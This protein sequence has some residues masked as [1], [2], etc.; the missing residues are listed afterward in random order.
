[1]TIGQ[2]RDAEQQV[3]LR[4]ER[5]RRR[6][7]RLIESH[8]TLPEVIITY[9]TRETSRAERLRQ[10]RIACGRKEKVVRHAPTRPTASNQKRCSLISADCR[11]PSSLPPSFR[12]AGARL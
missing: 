12:P 6:G 7:P 11:P 8:I 3:L 1:M 9:M 4:I 10:M 5:V 2:T